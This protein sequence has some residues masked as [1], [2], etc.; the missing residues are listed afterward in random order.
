MSDNNVE[1]TLYDDQE[2]Q[3]DTDSNQSS[4]SS[5]MYGYTGAGHIITYQE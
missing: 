5:G 1:D 4:I 2:M 3:Y